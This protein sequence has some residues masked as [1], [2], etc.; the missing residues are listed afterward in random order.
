[1]LEFSWI[2]ETALFDHEPALNKFFRSSAMRETFTGFASREH[3]KTWCDE[4]CVPD[5]VSFGYSAK[6]DIKCGGPIFECVITKTRD[7]YQHNLK[8]FHQSRAELLALQER[9]RRRLP[10]E[11]CSSKVSVIKTSL[12]YSSS[13]G[14]SSCVSPPVPKRMRNKDVERK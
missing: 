5:Q 7:L 8:L 9:K 3:A 10:S 11:E 1:M 14:T 2:Q 12:I 6:F 13:S 4:L